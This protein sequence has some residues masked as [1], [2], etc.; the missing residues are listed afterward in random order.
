M[1]PEIPKLLCLN[2]HSEAAGRRGRRRVPIV[3][4]KIG[5]TLRAAKV[6]RRTGSA[7]GLAVHI[8][9]GTRQGPIAVSGRLKNRRI[10]GCQ[11]A[12]DGPVLPQHLFVQNSQDLPVDD[13]RVIPV[14]GMP[15][16]L[17]NDLLA[18]S[19]PLEQVR[20]VHSRFPVAI[21]LF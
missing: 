1:I 11:S 8:R 7:K 14:N 16:I 5:P 9:T 19:R 2:V 3:E 20:L 4:L 12:A 17:D 10:R 18:V 21:G 15:G 13:F 6:P